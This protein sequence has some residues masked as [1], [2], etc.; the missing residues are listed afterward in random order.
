MNNKYNDYVFVFHATAENKNYINDN[1]K[2]TEVNNIEVISAKK[3]N[4][5][6]VQKKLQKKHNG[7]VGTSQ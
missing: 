4:T 5:L 7:I 2:K 3:K 1:I 6:F